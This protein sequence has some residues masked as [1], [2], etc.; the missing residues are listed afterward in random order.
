MSAYAEGT[1]V[2]AERSQ[3]E[4]MGLLRRYGASNFAYGEQ[5]GQAVVGFTVHDRSVR[6]VLPLPTDLTPYRQSPAGRK[7]DDKAAR[8]ALD[9]EHRRRWRALALAIK[10]KLEVVESGIATF[11]AEFLANIVLPGGDTVA[12]RVLPEVASAYE[13]GQAPPTLLAIGPGR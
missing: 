4:I 11:E 7:R 12:D 5:A 1:T 2:T 3:A 9:A 10:A 6:F 13:L 8:A